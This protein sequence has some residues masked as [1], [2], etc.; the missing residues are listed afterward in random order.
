VRVTDARGSPPAAGTRPSTREGECVKLRVT[1]EELFVV[2]IAVTTFG[3]LALASH[4]R[5]T[6]YNNLS[7]L[8]DAFVH[9]RY[10]IEGPTRPLD[11]PIWTNTNDALLWQGHR[12]VIEGLLPA[13]ILVPFAF[14]FGENTNQ[15]ALATV[16][17]TIAVPVA[18][19]L[20]RRIGT[21]RLDATILAAVFFAGTSLWW[22]AMLGD[23]WFIEHVSAVTFTLLAL[24]EL[25]GKRRGWVVALCAAAAFESRFTLVLAVPFYAAFL[26]RGGILPESASPAP[27]RIGASLRSFALTLL[28]V[29]IGYVVWNELRWHT[30]ADI[31]YTEFYH[32]DPWGQPD[33]SPFRLAYV[34]YEI[35]SFFLQSPVNVEYRQLA[36][37]PLFKLDPHGVALTWTTPILAL[38]FFARGSRTYRALMWSAILVLWFPSMVYYLDGWTQFGMRH[39]LDFEPF[40]FV[41]LAVA[42]RGGMPAWARALGVYCVLF[43]AWGVW[44]WDTTFRNYD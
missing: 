14:F 40:W 33:G 9:G 17:C 29:A 41:L 37:W 11:S 3:L 19:I 32:S 18:F 27:E 8:A 35:Y 26:A 24:L 21:S 44:F 16:L 30:F 36:L 38:A 20:F 22:C 34:P 7:L 42:A 28:P 25:T 1:S 15:T 12:Y 39:A 10:W 31:G 4:F 5:S 6:P 13:L 2:V 43:G 23:V